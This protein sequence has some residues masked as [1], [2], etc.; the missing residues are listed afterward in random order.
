MR[1]SRAP[2]IDLHGLDR[3]RAEAMIRSLIDDAQAVGDRRVEI[4]H[5]SGEGV[6]AKLVRDVL[7][8][9]PKVLD[10]GAL[11]GTAGVWARLKT[12]GEMPAD[13]SANPTNSAAKLARDL[14][15]ASKNLEPPRRDDGTR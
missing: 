14:L 8:T 7:K 6:L 5:G 4:V 10:I 11:D 12:L 15:R 9:H 13:R 3:E 2:R 1:V